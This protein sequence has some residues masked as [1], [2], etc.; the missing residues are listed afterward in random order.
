MKSTRKIVKDFLFRKE[1]NF[2]K[3]KIK[4]IHKCY[5]I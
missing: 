5:I 4:R 2:A 3:Q 1:K